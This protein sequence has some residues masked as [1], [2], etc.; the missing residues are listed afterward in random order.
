MIISRLLKYFSSSSICL[1]RLFDENDF[2]KAFLRDLSQAERE[3]IIE[4]PFISVNRMEL[5]FPVFERLL[6]R[7]VTIHIVTRDPAEHDENFRY[8]I[9][10]EILKCAEMGINV[11]LLRG[12]HHRK[13][14]IIDRSVL[15]EGSLN[16]LSHSKSREIMRR[17]DSHSEA[18]R[19]LQ[20]LNL[21]KVL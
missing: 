14:A 19:M 8:Q 15:W 16:I 1:S 18:V 4:S 2:Y 5:L 13:L 10:D 17:V 7:K 3:V 6:K 12:M 21:K 9:T 11:V 20:F